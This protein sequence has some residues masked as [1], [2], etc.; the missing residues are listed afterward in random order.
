LKEEGQHCHLRALTSVEPGGPQ[1]RA[2][3]P[4]EPDQRRLDFGPLRRPRAR[5]LRSSRVMRLK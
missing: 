1:H 5:T 3:D 4:C 2:A